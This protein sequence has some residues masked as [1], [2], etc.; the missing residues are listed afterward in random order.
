MLLKSVVDFII[1]VDNVASSG[2]VHH[3]GNYVNLVCEILSR[4]LKKSQNHIS[5]YFSTDFYKFEV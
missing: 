3:V 4:I 1:M 5:L 2:I